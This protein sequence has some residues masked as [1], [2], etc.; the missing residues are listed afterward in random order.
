MLAE[1]DSTTSG[2]G[3]GLKKKEMVECYFKKCVRLTDFKLIL[4]TPTA[5]PMEV[6]PAWMAWAILRMAI[7]PDEHSLFTTE[8]GTS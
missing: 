1:M 7:K 3:R 4:S 8:M 5:S 6:S 2:V